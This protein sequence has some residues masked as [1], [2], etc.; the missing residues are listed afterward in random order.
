MLARA[1]KPPSFANPTSAPRPE[2][3]CNRRKPNC[4]EPTIGTQPKAPPQPPQPF[5]AI[6]SAN[7]SSKP[8]NA[9]ICKPTR[10]PNQHRQQTE[11][12]L[13]RAALIQWLTKRAMASTNRASFICSF[14]APTSISACHFAAHL[15]VIPAFLASSPPLMPSWIYAWAA[16]PIIDRWRRTSSGPFARIHRAIRHH[17]LPH[18]Y[19]R[20][21][22]DHNPPPDPPAAPRRHTLAFFQRSINSTTL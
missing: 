11:T 6:P 21:Q 4:N 1:N 14:A 9:T 16:F 17:L 22:R 8:I 2:N 3:I 20:Q 7:R 5:A 10:R 19:R 18:A 15:A 12:L 13:P